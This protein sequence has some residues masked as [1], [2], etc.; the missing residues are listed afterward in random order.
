MCREC[1]RAWGHGTVYR[2]CFRGWGGRAGS[3]AQEVEGRL[4]MPIEL[5]ASLPSGSD[6]INPN[7]WAAAIAVSIQPA[8]TVVISSAVLNFCQPE[9]RF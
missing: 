6:H 9:D 5:R 1:L 4:K 3:L 7:A 8:L 2:L